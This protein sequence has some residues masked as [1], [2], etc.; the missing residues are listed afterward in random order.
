MLED[1]IQNQGKLT[2][3]LSLGGYVVDQRSGD[4]RVGHRAQF[5]VIF[6]SRILR[7]WTRRLLLL[8]IRS[9]QTSYFK[10]KVS[11]EEQRS[12]GG[13]VSSRKTDRL[14]DFATTFE[15][16]VLTMPSLIMLI[17]SLSLFV[18]TMFR[19]S[20]RDGTKFYYL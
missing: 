16:L 20:I 14:H 1:K 5:M 18:T 11:L 4:C 15:S 13:S 7:C 3:T 10:K 8:C 2:F 17:H 6:I 12:E 19:T 9:F